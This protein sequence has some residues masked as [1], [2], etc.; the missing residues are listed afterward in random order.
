MDAELR[1][2]IIQLSI[3]AIEEAD[4]DFCLSD[5]ERVKAINQLEPSAEEIVQLADLAMRQ[6]EKKARTYQEKE[7]MEFVSNSMEEFIEMYGIEEFDTLAEVFAEFQSYMRNKIHEEIKSV[8]RDE[9]IER[10]RE[11]YEASNEDL[12]A[13]GV[14]PDGVVEFEDVLREWDNDES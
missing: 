13:M 6:T 9:G 5:D 3:D 7:T 2:E 11:L 12:K 4:D 10:V 8:C 14:D 1:E